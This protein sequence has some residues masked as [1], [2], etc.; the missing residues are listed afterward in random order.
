M[1]SIVT[2]STADIPAP[3][4]AGSGITVV[5]LNVHFGDEVFRDRLDLDDAAFFKRLKS[6]PT[7]PT[8]SQPS[9]GA[10]EEAYRPL[11]ASGHEIISVHLSGKL[12]GTVSSAQ[13]A[14]AGLAPQYVSVVDSQAISMALG[15][16]ALMAAEMAQHGH[17]RETITAALQTLIPC[18]RLVAALDTLTYVQRGGRIGRAQ[19][20]L[21]SILNVKPLVTLL[22]GEVEP[23]GR[24]RSRRQAVDRMIDV[25]LRAGTLRRLAVL[26]GD[27]SEDA[28]LLRDR[29]AAHYP[30][31]DIP[32]AQIGPVVATHAG[33]GVLGLT[34]VVAAA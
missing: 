9:V 10:F 20:L 12:S 7:L 8:T 1:V 6:S 11:L 19:A 22:D 3:L 14:A 15:F 24:A 5:P 4:L 17:L 29:L 18:T 33:P 32:V 21:G 2:D 23:L 25:L 27:A 28:R 34:Y 16:L 26:H 13:T 30:G 31:L